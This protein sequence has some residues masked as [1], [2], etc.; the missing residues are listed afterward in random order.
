[1]VDLWLS[2]S[3]VI[4]WW[5]EIRTEKRLLWSVPNIQYLNGPPS[6][7]TIPFENQTHSFWYSDG[8]CVHI[9]IEL[10]TGIV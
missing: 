6:Y 2:N 4:E 7:T 10:T 5:S 8:S 3:P 1:M 9:L